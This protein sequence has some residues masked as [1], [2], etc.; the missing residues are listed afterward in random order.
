MAFDEKFRQR[1]KDICGEYDSMEAAA[2]A[3]SVTKSQIYKHIAGKSEPLFITISKLCDNIGVS[4]DWIVSG[5]GNK[6]LK[7]KGEHS[8]VDNDFF[9]EVVEFV[10]S[11]LKHE[12]Y[13]PEYR[14]RIKLVVALYNFEWRKA[15]EEGR[16][17]DISN[18]NVVD[19]MKYML[20]A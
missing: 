20:A 17:P 14:D 10:E 19:F 18:D 11:F 8:T 5:R 3:G 9:Q 6:Y 13:N 7:D 4:L 2:K 1:Y 12:K 16:K 15:A